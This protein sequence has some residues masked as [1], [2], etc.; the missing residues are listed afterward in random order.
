MPPAPSAFSRSG[1]PFAP[2]VE[3]H[4][5]GGVENCQFDSDLLVLDRVFEAQ[6]IRCLFNLGPKERPFSDTSEDTVL[7]AA[8]GGATREKLPGH[9]ALFWECDW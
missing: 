8:I 6:R 9:S 3:W 1:T 4:S 7:I 5:L 2:G